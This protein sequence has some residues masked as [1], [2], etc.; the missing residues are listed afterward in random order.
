MTTWYYNVKQSEWVP[1]VILNADQ[2][3]TTDFFYAAFRNEDITEDVLINGAVFVYFIDEDGRDNLLP[4]EKYLLGGYGPYQEMLEYQIENGVITF[5]L[6]STDFQID[7][8][9][10]NLGTLKFKVVVLSSY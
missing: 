10:D 5:I 7:Q 2:T 3:Y 1:H 9:V 4:Y 6:K 8:T